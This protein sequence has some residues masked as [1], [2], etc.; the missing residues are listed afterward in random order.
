MATTNTPAT[1]ETFGQ[2]VQAITSKL[3]LEVSNIGLKLENAMAVVEKDMPAVTTELNAALAVLFPGAVLP[4]EA[5]EKIAGL[6]VAMLSN[7]GKA[8]SDKG[9][10]VDDDQASAVAISALSA[11]VK[12]LKTKST[13]VALV[14]PVT[15]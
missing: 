7:T 15:K 10:S 3:E 2:K 14:A 8:M 13:P 6:A 12:S 4:A 1:P 9:L 5:V 11:A